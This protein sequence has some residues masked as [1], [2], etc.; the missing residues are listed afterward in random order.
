LKR[1]NF[2]TVFIL[3]IDWNAF[4]IGVILGELDKEGQE[5]V[6]A[7]ASRSNNKVENNYF[8]YEGECLV[9]VYISGPIFMALISLCISTTS[10]SN[11]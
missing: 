7:Y 1:P 4:D 2:N 3:H 5:Y 10:L 9:V 6:I 8:S 11:G